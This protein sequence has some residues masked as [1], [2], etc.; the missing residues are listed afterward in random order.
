MLARSHILA[1]F[2]QISEQ[3]IDS[4]SSAQGTITI[5]LPGLP[6]GVNVT[7]SQDT[8]FVNDGRTLLERNEVRASNLFSVLI[9]VLCLACHAI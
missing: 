2:L 5:S 1:P 7:K 3:A 8:F 9:A 4:T 6:D